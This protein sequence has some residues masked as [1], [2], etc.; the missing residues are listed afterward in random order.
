MR[1]DEVTD[2]EKLHALMM[3][4]DDHICADLLALYASRLHHTRTRHRDHDQVLNRLAVARHQISLP[5]TPPMHTHLHITSIQHLCLDVV[6]TLV[7]QQEQA[8]E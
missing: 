7:Q 5:L 3:N 6:Q 1:H 2:E 8:V 4:D